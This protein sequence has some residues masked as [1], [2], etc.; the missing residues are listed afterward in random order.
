ML[1]HLDDILP[2]GIDIE[3]CLDPED[4][5]VRELDIREPVSGSFNIRKVGHQIVVR[6]TV[7]GDVKLRCARCL[8]EFD[9]SVQEEVEIELRPVFDLER[10]G[11]DLELG[12]DDLDIDFFVGDAL[13]LGHIVAEQI[14]LL[15]PMKP[16]CKEDCAGICSKCGAKRAENPCNCLAEET[17]DRWGELLKLKEQMKNNNKGD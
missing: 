13:D 16:L 17:D 10:S 12:S 3:V 9:F 7:V 4:P 2:E 1:L 15:I 8:G 5:A 11:H 6:G 14:A